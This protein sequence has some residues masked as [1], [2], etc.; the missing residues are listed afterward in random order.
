MFLACYASHDLSGSEGTNKAKAS[1]SLLVG[2]SKVLL[3][4]CMAKDQ[5][6]IEG[7]SH[8]GREWHGFTFLGHIALGKESIAD[9]L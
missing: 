6:R 3:A 2:A 9:D 1:G 8:A 7:C 5:L 4:A